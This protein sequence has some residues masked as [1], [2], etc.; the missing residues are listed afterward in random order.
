VS[1]TNPIDPLQGLIS[2]ANISIPPLPV[3]AMNPAKWVYERIVL[4]IKEFEEGLDQEHEIGARLVTFGPD[5]T[6]HIDDVGY[7]GPDIIIFHGVDKNNRKVQ[8]LQHITQ[9]N[10]LLIA[11]DKKQER[12][13]RIGFVLLDK[14][15]KA[16]S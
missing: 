11:L 4:S 10:V 2:A 5:L 13:R 8:L 7:W 12:A 1:G 15:E 9:L 16:K 6:F 3:S 14:I